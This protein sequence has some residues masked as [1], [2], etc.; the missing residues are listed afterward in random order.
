MAIKQEHPRNRGQQKQGPVGNCVCIMLRT[1][2]STV[3]E[4]NKQRG[5]EI[6]GQSSNRIPQ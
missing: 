2:G 5:K 4:V 3:S 6:R 1:G